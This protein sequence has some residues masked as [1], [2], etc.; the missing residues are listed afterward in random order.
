MK[1]TQPLIR[2]LILLTLVCQFALMPLFATATLAV[3]LPLVDDFENGLPS[4]LD[5]TIGIGFNTFQDPNSTVAI[6]TTNA[7]PAPVP[8]AAT[9]NNVLQMNV[10]VVSFAGFAHGFENA[11]VDQWVPQDWSAYA[12]ISFWLYGNNSNTTLFIDILDNRNPGATTD[13]AERWS[14]DLK[15]DF[16]G[17]REI[18]VP[19]TNLRR[20]EIG[21]GA[22]ND[23]LGLTEV[24]GWAFGAITTASPQVYYLDN[25]TLYG[26]APVRPLTLGFSTINYPV[27]EG[28]GA[29][30]TV[31]LSKPATTT[32]TVDYATKFGAAIVDRDYTAVAGT[33]T[34]P[35]NSTQQSF[36]VPTINDAK[37]QGERGVLVELSNP[38]GGAAMG[39][40]PVARVN[41]LDNESYDPT[42]LD[43]FESYPYLWAANANAALTNTEIPQGALQALPG[44]GDYEGVLTVTPVN[45]QA[46]YA[47]S[48]TFPLAQDWSASAGLRFWYYGQNSGQAIQVQVTNNQAAATDPSQWQ[49]LW[50][51]EFN[52][53]AG[54]PPNPDVWGHEV[55]DGTVNG[56]PGWGNDE[57]EYY[58]DSTDNAA[59]D[60]NGNLVITTKAAD[61]SLQC[62]YGPCQY[63]SARLL[64]KNR[65]E[66]AY[67]RIEA[68]VK[69]A[70]GAG[71][72]PAFWML[73]TDIDRVGWPQ[74]GEIDIM[75]YVGRLPN[76]IF[77]TI[78]GPGYSGGQSYGQ[79]YDLGELVANNYH[80]FAV[81]WEPNKIVWYLNG[82]VYHQATPNDAFL[83]GKQWVYNHPFFM[84]LNVAVGGN[85]GGAVGPET[86]FPQT[87]LV[88]YIRLYQTPPQPVAFTAT[89]QD[90][91]SGW[92]LITLPL[93]A[94]QSP[95][96][97]TP[98]LTA[99][100]SLGFEVP[101][102]VA[103]P[104]MMDQVQLN[105]DNTITVTSNADSGV[106]SLRSALGNVCAGGT[107]QADASLA[108][109][110][111]TLTSGPLT[112][113]KNVT[114]D[115][116]AAPG[117]IISGNNS[118]R[119][120]VVN[121]GVT[122]TLRAL[123]LANGYGYELAGGVLNNGALTLE[124][125][126]LTDNRVTTGGIDFWKGGGGIY[127]G[128]GSTLNLVESTVRNNSVTG[129]AGGGVYGFFNTTVTIERSTIYSNTA[130]DVGG[131]IRSLGNFTIRN[132]TIS[133]NSSTGWQGGAF[134]H[135]DGVMNII[136]STIANNRAPADTTGGGFVGT[137]TASNATLTLVNTI[138]TGN[139]GTQCFYAPW[140]AGTVTLTS[141]GHNLVADGSCGI[142]APN[143]SDLIGVDAK[144]GPLADNG[145]PTLTHALQNSSPA[146]NAAAVGSCP[147]NDQRNITRP[148]GAGCDI[149]AYEAVQTPGRALINI[150]VDTQPDSATNLGF[151]GTL[152]GFALDDVVV[153]DGDA[154]TNT[155]TFTVAPGSYSVQRNNS[156]T[157]LTT[158]IV[159]TPQS[160]AAID[161]AQRRV[162]LTVAAGDDVTCTFTVVRSVTITA[163][164][165]NDLVRNNTNLGKRNAA[166]PWL[167]NWTMT[168]ATAPTATV[169]STVTQPTAVANVYSA[170]FRYLHPGS[171][172]VCTTLPGDTWTLTTPTAIDPAYGRPCKA[173]T[174]QP[175]QRALLLFGAYQ[176]MGVA[177]TSVT[178]EAEMI[179]D[180]DGI[181]EQPDD[182]NVDETVEAEENLPRLFLP[183]IQR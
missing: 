139:S 112:L 42:L 167:Q 146:R 109:Q 134:F 133:G 37:Y 127:N 34:F 71:L 51:D 74:T 130:N 39:L 1:L 52:N 66:V 10:N 61:G 3:A 165:F 72:W 172:T 150:I 24:H 113:G 20:K 160:G 108:G 96:G 80:T 98:D 32:V 129:G 175:G 137:F 147:A 27:T 17:W 63:T 89:F 125:V 106:G 14:V 153:D 174:L 76:E 131:G 124:R 159:C 180:E 100:H 62:Y 118:D 171:Y 179:T 2:T 83:Q 45:N 104:V 73:G 11:S 170:I 8:G 88:D 99:I 68:R 29:N 4:G 178:A 158:A 79:S 110:T 140:G 156:Q 21:N 26:T 117:L 19:F 103:A 152:R 121:S 5:G 82:N 64:T 30:I 54:T 143:G 105:C 97:Q 23:G 155:R 78:H 16:S 40:P 41:I 145:G 69:V 163:R 25:V 90:N 9:P 77:G 70:Q 181:S 60:G 126:V 58:T 44:Q 144:L 132:S 35:P 115:G 43:D 55:G 111:I 47:F 101:A 46:S 176:P 50:S 149:G 173:V 59:T 182:P 102:G 93:A 162:T 164:A 33:L 95:S 49:L 136:N 87:T 120:V 13:D 81:E 183:L 138:L 75:E 56:I 128:D 116:S 22:P 86:T 36:T 94:F 18:Q 28:N 12:G 48:R 142:P 135:T 31:K 177:S 141:L 154:Y 65:F 15:D 7:P 53:P 169:A 67:G 6:V 119:V 38:T 168:L 157:W 166:D 84:L 148:Q 114:I 161:L 57:L 91:F 151:N 123:T 85:F 92:Q 107:I 122:A